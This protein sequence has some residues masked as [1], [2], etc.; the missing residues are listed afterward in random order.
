MVPAKSE[1]WQDVA[2]HGVSALSSED[3]EAQKK[4]AQSSAKE[5]SAA[6]HIKDLSLIEDKT[7]GES[8]SEKRW[9]EDGNAYTEEEFVSFLGPEE[10]QRQWAQ[11]ERVLEKRLADDG[12]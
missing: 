4:Q 12:K 7:K 1:V 5:D 9:A 8:P 2:A 3:V 10:A 6:E 11:A